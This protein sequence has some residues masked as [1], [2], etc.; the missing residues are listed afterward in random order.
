MPQ[1]IPSY[2]LA[3]AAGDLVFQSV[4]ERAGVWAEP[5]VV[6][7]HSAEAARH[8]ASQCEHH[9]ISRSHIALAALAQRIAEAA[10]DGWAA[11]ATAAN[12]ADHALLALARDLCQTVARPET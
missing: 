12:L 4:S 3:I 9:A 11:V 5:A 8:F 10:G 1:P 7:L 2:L 6:A